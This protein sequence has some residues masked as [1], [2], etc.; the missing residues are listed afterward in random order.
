MKTAILVVGALLLAGSFGVERNAAAG[1]ERSGVTAPKSPKAKPKA[2]KAETKPANAKCFVMSGAE[3]AKASG[4]KVVS[5]SG[6]ANARGLNCW[7]GLSGRCCCDQGGT[8]VCVNCNR[9]Y[10]GGVLGVE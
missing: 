3:L 8:V 10:G 9:C 7:C 6:T 5:G 2:P 1:R 4:K